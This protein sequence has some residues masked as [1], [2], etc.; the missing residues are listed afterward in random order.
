MK[1]NG[2]AKAKPVNTMDP[3][4]VKLQREEVI[5]R[6]S[7]QITKLRYEIKAL[8]DRKEKIEVEIRDAFAAERAK[9]YETEQ[10]ALKKLASAS[11]ERQLIINERDLFSAEK[12]TAEEQIAC[13][14]KEVED[15]LARNLKVL[16]EINL[17][18]DEVK[19]IRTKNH[20]DA[21]QLIEK[22]KALVGYAASIEKENA[23]L[24][25]K[26]AQIEND[27]KNLEKEIA[28]V[29]A[30]KDLADRAREEAKAFELKALQN[31]SDAETILEKSVQ[32]EKSASE[33]LES[34]EE[35][36]RA[37][38][39]DSK[40]IK[41]EREKFTEWENRLKVWEKAF[42]NDS[43]VR[44]RDLDDRESRIKSLEAKLGG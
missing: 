32:L 34:A 35:M 22:E 24:S 2:F 42:N 41:D 29:Q 6:Y 39:R 5:K 26:K 17:A 44:K 19:A 18:R 15:V 4:Y 38:S 40:N 25:A 16:S 20:E 1:N 37:V 14:Q 23:A 10:V 28:A 8:E 27:R 30:E 12:K 3:E 9:I 11:D 33:K 43:A 36:K 31:R 21:A 13:Q 7:G